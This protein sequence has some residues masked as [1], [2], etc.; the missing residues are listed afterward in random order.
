MLPKKLCCDL[1]EQK[2]LLK[3]RL[4]VRV[5]NFELLNK[6]LKIVL[7]ILYFNPKVACPERLNGIKII[8]IH[9]DQKSHTWAPKTL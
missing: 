8:K 9:Q 5:R 7:S 4:S 1:P 6:P 2:C 3:V